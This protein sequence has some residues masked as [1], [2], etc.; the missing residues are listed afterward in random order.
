MAIIYQAINRINGK[1][2]VG[3][4]TKTIDARKQRHAYD[5]KYGRK[6]YFGNAIRYYGINNFSF[7][8]L[9]ETSVSDVDEQERMWIQKIAPEYNMTLGGEGGDVSKSPNFIQAM[10]LINKEGAN[11]HMFGKYGA[12]NPN[13]GQK[14]GRSPLISLGLKKSWMKRKQGTL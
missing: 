4:S 9:E 8:V 10:K 13:Y 1:K 12:D 3:K 14:R 2:Y 6:T 11:N 7:S 5:A